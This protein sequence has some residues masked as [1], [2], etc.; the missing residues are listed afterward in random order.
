MSE[1]ISLL[2]PETLRQQVEAALRQGIMSGHFS[3][4]ARLVE[5]ELCE[6]LGVSRT[7]IREAL[8]KLESEKLVCIVP[9]KGPVVA[10]IS[11][12]EA[13]DLYAIRALLESYAATEFARS[14]DEGALAEF[15][16]CMA[17]LKASGQ[18]GDRAAVL[19][20][21]SAVYD[22][23]LDNCGNSLAKEILSGLYSRINLLRA[24]SLAQENRLPASLK[25]M[26]KLHRAIKARDPE[27]AGA[28]ARIHVLNA[29]KAAMQ[30][31]DK[32]ELQNP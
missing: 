25:E 30:A 1:G 16:A 29:E 7:S 18:N 9:H 11:K 32:A 24:A 13:M 20:A 8:R 15:S 28:A 31:L 12:R 22:V 27:A 23:L 4:G 19:K 6:M 14:A 26:E 17:V 5:R 2:R 21:K 3:P 10:V